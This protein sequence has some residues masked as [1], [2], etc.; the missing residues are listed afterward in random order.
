MFS[1]PQEFIWFADFLE[2]E[3]KQQKNMAQ[4]C[5]DS[6]VSVSMLEALKIRYTTES[7]DEQQNNNCEII[8]ARPRNIYHSG[9][10]I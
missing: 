4:M 2:Q 10:Y 3:K 5:S 9:K 1:V 8:L 6:D 7:A